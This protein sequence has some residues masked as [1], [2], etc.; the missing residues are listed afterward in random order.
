MRI[1]TGVLLA[2][3]RRRLGRR[4]LRAATPLTNPR[5]RIRTGGSIAGGR[6]HRLGRRYPRAA[7][8]LTNRM[9]IR[10]GRSTP[11]A[12]TMTT[13]AMRIRTSLLLALVAACAARPL[14]PSPR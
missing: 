4:D 8:P 6:R 10:T 11:Q 13:P 1:R 7:T 5:M 14:R 9:R 3:A 12:A 2:G